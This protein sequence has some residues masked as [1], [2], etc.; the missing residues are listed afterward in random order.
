MDYNNG[1]YNNGYPQPYYGNAGAVPDRLGQYRAPYQQ[2]GQPVQMPAQ[3]VPTFANMPSNAP[4][5]NPIWVQGEE[6]AKAYMVARNSTVVLWDV[7]NPV[8]YLKSA[9]ESGMP[10][11]RIFD[12]KER[13]SFPKEQPMSAVPNVEYIT[14]GEFDALKARLD[15]LLQRESSREYEAKPAEN[16]ANVNK[17]KEDKRNG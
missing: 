4:Q 17:P 2:Q 10:S 9:D 15:E 13:V 16:R 12:L 14:R 7:E 6:G 11:M 5:N 1:Y 8:I 3:N